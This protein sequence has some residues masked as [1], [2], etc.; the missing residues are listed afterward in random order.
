MDVVQKVLQIRV[1]ASLRV[2]R[3]LFT[4]NQMIE[5][6]DADGQRLVLL[7]LDHELPQLNIFDQLVDDDVVQVSR[8]GQ[9][10]PVFA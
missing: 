4:R 8:F 9:V 3:G 6:D 10:P 7:R 2:D 1:H 5:L